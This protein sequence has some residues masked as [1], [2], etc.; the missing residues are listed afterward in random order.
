M[1]W[2]NAT[3]EEARKEFIVAFQ[4]EEVSFSALCRYFGI[5]RP[6]G[7]KWLGRFAREG[8]LADRSRAPHVQR[9]ATPGWQ[10]TELLGLRARHPLWGPK[11]LLSVLQRQKP[12][13]A[14]PAPSTVGEILRREGLTHP[15]PRRRRTPPGQQPLSHAHEPN[16]VWCADFKGW[17]LCGDGRRCDPLTVTD[18]YSR[19]LIRCRH[20]PKTDGPHVREIFEAAFREC[21]LPVAIRT[22][23]GPPFASTG[24]GGLSRLAVWWLR[25]GIRPER[26]EPGS[27]QQNGRHERFHQTL[28]QATASPPRANLRLQQHAFGRFQREYNCERPHEA[29]GQRPPVEFYR[30]SPRPFPDRLPHLAYPFACNLRRISAAGHLNWI[31]HQ[32]YISVLLADQDVA[33]REVDDDLLEVHFG[34]LLLDWV[35]VPSATFTAVKAPPLRRCPPPS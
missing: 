21:G 22:D 29:L 12:E 32:I 24:V 35:D 13:A 16:A 6:T 14:W 31:Q 15:R 23:N 2:R 8:S 1:P 33:L 11:E 7:Y 20:V 30:P 10:Q 25:L 34:P 27:P 5:S 18:A 3:V 28:Q 19:Y 4:R 9:F 17:F 26:I